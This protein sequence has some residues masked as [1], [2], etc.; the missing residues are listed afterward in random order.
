MKDSNRFFYSPLTQNPCL[1]NFRKEENG[2]RLNVSASRGDL[3]FL[4]TINPKSV[5]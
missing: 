5:L 1:E 2:R 3:F 4:F